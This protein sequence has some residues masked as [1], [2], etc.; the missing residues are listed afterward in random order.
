M[1]GIGLLVVGVGTAGAGAWMLSSASGEQADIDKQIEGK[2]RG[3][4]LVD[5]PY[6]EY[7]TE[8]NLVNGRVVRGGATLGVGAVVAAVGAWLVWATPTATSIAFD[9]RPGQMK[10]QVT[11]GF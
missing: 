7:K 6:A 4:G 10:L 5:M 8:Q 9:P 1:I 2:T 11:V 3:D